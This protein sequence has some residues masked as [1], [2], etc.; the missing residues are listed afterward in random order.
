[1]K[2][3]LN[4]PCPEE[5]MVLLEYGYPHPESY[6]GISE[7]QCISCGKRVGRWS[8]RLLTG[9]EFEYRFGKQHEQL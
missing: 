6:D 5:K 8:G 2:E 3:K 9:D 7:I 4:C 1:M